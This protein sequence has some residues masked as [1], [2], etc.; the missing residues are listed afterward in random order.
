MG[1]SPEEEIA[2]MFLFKKSPEMPAPEQALP[3]RSTPIATASRHFVN[4]HP[5]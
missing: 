2:V 1:D 4:G 3:G 5:L